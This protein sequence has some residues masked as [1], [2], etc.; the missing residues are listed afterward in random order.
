MRGPRYEVFR[1]T[2]QGKTE[3]KRLVVRRQN[4]WLRD[5]RYWFGMTSVEIF[6]AVVSKV[7]M[8]NND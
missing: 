1:L 7:A 4:S 6:R 3:G 2:I 5:L 8:I